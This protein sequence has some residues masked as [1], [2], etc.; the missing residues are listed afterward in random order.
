MTTTD[1]WGDAAS[2][3]RT[4]DLVEPVGNTAPEPTFT[5]T[6]A[7]FTT[8]TFNSAGTVDDQ[9]DVIRYSWAFGDG[10]TST[11]ANPSRTYATTGTY[12][13]FL[14]VT[15]VWGKSETL[16]DDVTVSAPPGNDAPTAV[17][18]SGTCSAFTTC[19]MSGREQ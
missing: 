10:G 9:G 1:G 5:A 12:S 7:S 17:I 13:V 8:C 15:D 3:T 6:C 18:A 14:D 2:T 4:I 11:S 19:A 16:S